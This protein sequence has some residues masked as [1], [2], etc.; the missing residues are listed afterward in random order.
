LFP[1]TI[2]VMKYGFSNDDT[3]DC[4]NS[5]IVSWAYV[6]RICVHERFMS[7]FSS[8]QRV[9]CACPSIPCLHVICQYYRRLRPNFLICTCFNIRP[10]KN[11]FVFSEKWNLGTS[12]LTTLR[13]YYTQK[14]AVKWIRNYGALWRPYT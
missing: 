8:Y 6:I 12:K 13:I 9:V 10:I 2:L 4:A 3:N 11:W 5:I 14:L 1:W 7:P